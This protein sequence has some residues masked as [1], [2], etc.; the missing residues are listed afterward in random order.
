MSQI[1]SLPRTFK[2]PDAPPPAPVKTLTRWSLF[3]G[4][5]AAGTPI[6]DAMLKH[7]M[8]RADIE[9]CIRDNAEERQRWNEARLAARKRAWSA[10]DIEDI[11]GRIAGGMPVVESVN[12][13][14]PGAADDFTF[15]CTADPAWNAM[16]MAALKARAILEG[17]KVLEIVDD[18]SNDTIPGRWGD[19]P[20]NAAV[21]RSK[22]RAESRM[23]LMGSWYPKLFGEKK[24]DTQVNVQV[25]YAAKLEEARARRDTRKALPL[26]RDVVDAVFQ[27]SPA[28]E[29]PEWDDMPAEAPVSTV[30]RETE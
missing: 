5:I 10:F 16:Y 20:N 25:N 4:D 22:L 23:R 19:V 17:E 11:L 2:D 9:A 28:E 7:Y 27:E 24:G 12:M 21:N 1:P 6:Q 8:K 13:S 29:K 30:W 18:T 26:S 3:L 15:L 14:R